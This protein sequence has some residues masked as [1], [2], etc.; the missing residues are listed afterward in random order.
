MHLP[1]LEWA[2]NSRNNTVDILT[3]SIIIF[4]WI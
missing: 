2:F 1:F 4:D 3:E